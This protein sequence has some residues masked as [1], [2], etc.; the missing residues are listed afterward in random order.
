MLRRLVRGEENGSPPSSTPQEPQK[1]AFPNAMPQWALYIFI[2][3][4]VMGIIGIVGI[5]L[6]IILLVNGSVMKTTVNEAQV[7]LTA[8]GESAPAIAFYLQKLVNISTLAGSIVPEE[9][10]A[11]GYFTDPVPGVQYVF[12]VNDTVRMAYRFSGP[13]SDTTSPL[14]VFVHSLSSSSVEWIEQMNRHGASATC[15][16]AIDLLGHGNSDS[17][18]LMSGGSVP[19]QASYLFTF[20]T[21]A[22]LLDDVERRV[23]LCGNAFGG[24]I[25]MQFHAEHP[26]VADAIILENPMPYLVNPM[27]PYA[28]QSAITGAVSAP[29]VL[30]LAGLALY[31]ASIYTELIATELGLGSSCSPSSLVPLTEAYRQMALFAEAIAITDGLI[32]LSTLDHQGIF[33]GLIIPILLISGAR[34]GVD[35]VSSLSYALLA[36]TARNLAQTQATLHVIGSAASAVHLTHS[37]LFY[38]L[39]TQ[40]LSG[41]DI[42]CDMASIAWSQVA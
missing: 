12:I 34:T 36:E 4:I 41:I 14:I 13:C 19:N 33:S 38:L 7:Y 11:D 24:S 26:G 18:E 42:Q 1:Y 39:S 5:A 27:D 15:A 16:I 32:S 17:V 29:E 21:V 6:T 40:F 3:V 8:L 25:I 37:H 2:G 20:M 30:Q 10:F 31:N 23:T 35:N 22:G 9:V 28:L